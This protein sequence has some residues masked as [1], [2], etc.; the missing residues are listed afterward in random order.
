MT[1]VGKTWRRHPFVLGHRYV[2]MLSFHGRTGSMFMEGH[3]YKLVD[4][5]YSH[6]DGCT[7][8]AFLSDG[9]IPIQWWWSDDEP[10]DLCAVRFR[11]S[12]PTVRDILRDYESGLYAA[13]ETVARSIDAL[14]G[15]DQRDQLWHSLPE[16]I[17]QQIDMILDEFSAGEERVTFGHRDPKAAHDELVEMKRWRGRARSQ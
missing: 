4:V 6:Y 17:R 16:W 14:V 2:A 3:S 13:H 9:Q 7:V 12:M 15:S 1:I 10:E 11:E 5:T 8:F